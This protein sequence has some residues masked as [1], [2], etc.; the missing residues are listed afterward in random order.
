MLFWKICIECIEP[1]QEGLVR[2]DFL[3]FLLEILG[4]DS[5]FGDGDDGLG[6]FVMGDKRTTV[7][8]LPSH[9]ARVI[10]SIVEKLVEKS[11]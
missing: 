2:G 6:E 8:V 4:Y 1:V 5:G 10:S 11:I 3:G 9:V 7:Q